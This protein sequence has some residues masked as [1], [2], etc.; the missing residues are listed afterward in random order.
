MT[1][2]IDIDTAAGG[3]EDTVAV[4]QFEDELWHTLA[5]A[6][7]DRRTGAPRLT[8]AIDRVHRRRGRRLIVTG[9][10]S[11]AAAAT[12]V[13][14]LSLRDDPGTGDAPPAEVDLAARIIA[15]TDEATATMIVHTRLT[16]GGEYEAWMDETSGSVRVLTLDLSGQ[17][18]WDSHP[19]AVPTDGPS[20]GEAARSLDYCFRQ[21]A[22][23]EAAIDHEAGTLA[24]EWVQQGLAEGHLVEDGT[25]VV[26]GRELIRLV[27]TS[28]FV[29]TPDGL[30]GSGSD[31]APVGFEVVEGEATELV[32]DEVTTQT[33]ARTV[34]VD[35]DTYRPARAV[36][37]ATGS[38]QTYEYL[39]RT[40]ENL[41]LMSPAVPAGFTE[42][43]EL[44]DAVE[45]ETAGCP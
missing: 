28:P 24:T 42:V 8:P 22:P 12:L 13:V 15:A 45:R 17:P 3:F 39:E 9:V 21:Y 10:G 34:W 5:R 36:D 6:H 26:D 20:A 4:P 14:A 43:A 44:P 23:V 16:M 25:E 18:R 7:E 31:E 27:E 40:P 1:N 11:V 32:P 41:A 19:T 35:P 29:G 37:S 30:E 38:T 2:D 33:G